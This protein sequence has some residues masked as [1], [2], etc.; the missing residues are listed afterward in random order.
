MHLY[1][2]SEEGLHLYPNSNHSGSL[3]PHTQQLGQHSQQEERCSQQGEDV[4]PSREVTAA[5]RRGVAPS[6]EV[7]ACTQGIGSYTYSN[8]TTRYNPTAKETAIKVLTAATARNRQQLGHPR[9]SQQAALT[10]KRTLPQQRGRGRQVRGCGTLA[11]R[12]RYL[13]TSTAKQKD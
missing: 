13:Q 3:N 11:E 5:S 8:Q 6:R 9:Q 1:S 7:T 2:R 10:L 12:S 4:V